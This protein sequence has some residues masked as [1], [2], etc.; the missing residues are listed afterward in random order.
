MIEKKL[1]IFN[2][3]NG[4]LSVKD[5]FNISHCVYDFYDFKKSVVEFKNH[6]SRN[7]SSINQFLLKFKLNEYEMI[8]V[9]NKKDFL[10]LL[11]TYNIKLFVEII[12]VRMIPQNL[13]IYAKNELYINTNKITS[14]SMIKKIEIFIDKI[15][16]MKD[17]ILTSEQ[18]E[19]YDTIVIP[20]IYSMEK[21][22]FIDVNM[23]NNKLY[24]N[25]I[26]DA[27]YKIFDRVRLFSKYTT[28]DSLIRSL[29]K[30]N[31]T[32]V[33]IDITSAVLQYLAK[34]SLNG[35]V[36]GASPINYLRTY[37]PLLNHLDKSE[38][39]AFYNNLIF[40]PKILSVADIATTIWSN[41]FISLLL[42]KKKEYYIEFEKNKYLISPISGMKIQKNINKRNY[43][44][45]FYQ[46][47][48]TELNMLIVNRFNQLINND[49]TIIDKHNNII[50][51]KYDSFVFDF[52]NIEFE[53]GQA[54]KKLAIFNDILSNELNILYKSESCNDLYSNF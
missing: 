8:F 26:V 28:N 2:G 41:K 18:N 54:D 23:Y 42:H 9:Y 17:H 4:I 36:F 21:N 29:H 34:V 33:E 51:Y 45:L 50:M 32:L 52:S 30:Q 12:D 22:K 39:K 3:V 43:M 40:N 5:T 1:Y 25:Y 10:H 15:F 53:N 48:E 47:I 16:A 20:A 49:E 35:F 7:I 6:R 31:G 37:I 13:K 11:D 27:N 14:Y 24:K 46:T 44:S 19:F 38:I